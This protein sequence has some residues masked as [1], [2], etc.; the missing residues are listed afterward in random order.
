MKS[1][2]PGANPGF[3]KINSV[4]QELIIIR[5]IMVFGP[6]TFEPWYEIEDEDLQEMSHIWPSLYTIL[7]LALSI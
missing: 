4:W 7:Y 6:E 2:Q 1:L 5:Y 3:I